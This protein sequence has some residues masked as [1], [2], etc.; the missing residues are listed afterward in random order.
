MKDQSELP[1][2]LRV[3]PP[4]WRSLDFCERFSKA[5]ELE[6]ELDALAKPPDPLLAI[7]TATPRG[8]V[9]MST[10]GHVDSL[11]GAG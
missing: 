4:V 1:E 6:Q 10:R 8:Q 3:A 5:L 11:L 7:P 2:A 9:R